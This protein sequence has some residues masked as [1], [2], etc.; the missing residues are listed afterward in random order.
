M[1]VYHPHAD[2]HGLNEPLLRRNAV[3]VCRVVQGGTGPLPFLRH[4]HVGARQ[5]LLHLRR[6]HLNIVQPLL[7]VGDNSREQR[8]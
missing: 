4:Q 6:G 2:L 1:T 3:L 8:R 5:T 7:Q